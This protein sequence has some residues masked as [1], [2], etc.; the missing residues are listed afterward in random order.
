LLAHPFFSD[1]SDEAFDVR[2]LYDAKVKQLVNKY[3]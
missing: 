1:V 2:E 3:V